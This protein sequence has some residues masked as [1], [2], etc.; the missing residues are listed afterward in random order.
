[1]FYHFTLPGFPKSEY[2]CSERSSEHITYQLAQYGQDD[3]HGPQPHDPRSFQRLVWEKVAWHHEQGGAQ[4]LQP[5]I[6]TETLPQLEQRE[7]MG[8]D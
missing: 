3:A 4:D 7:L 5:V 6:P 2:L 8:K 1:M